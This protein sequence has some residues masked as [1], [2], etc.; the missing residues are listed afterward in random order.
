M[1]M[2]SIPRLNNIYRMVVGLGTL[3]IFAG[4]FLPWFTILGY[5]DLN[6]A[7]IYNAIF[8]ASS[9]LS[10]SA[11]PSLIPQLGQYFASAA[12]ILGAI[13][14]YPIALIAGITSIISRRMALPAGILGVLTGLMWTFGVESLKSAIEQQ[15]GLFGTFAALFVTVG[16][17]AYTPMIGGVLFIIGYFVSK[18]KMASPNG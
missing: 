8:Q 14:L 10:G 1:V 7:D 3:I 6:L 18:P 2:I 16:Y 15:A 13:V 12:G 5:I 9:Q 11:P 4:L 17:G